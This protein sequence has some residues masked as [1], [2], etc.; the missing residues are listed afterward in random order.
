MDITSFFYRISIYEWIII[1]I[2]L[3]FFIVQLFYYLY[4]FRKP[5]QHAAKIYTANDNIDNVETDLPGVTIIITAKNEEEN[6]K[7]NLPFI[8]N[9]DYLN[10]QVVVVDNGSTDSTMD[11]LNSFKQNHD[12]LYITYIPKGSEKVN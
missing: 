5:Y 6:I 2:Y 1:G 10:F 3:F 4:L 8:L 12:N 7:K 9:Q 11:V